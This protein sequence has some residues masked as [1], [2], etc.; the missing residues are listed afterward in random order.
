MRGIR[1]RLMLAF[2]VV[3][4]VTA[5][6]ALVL[7][8]V[9]FERRL[10]G[11][12]PEVR[13]QV[14]RRLSV[15]GG[16]FDGFAELSAVAGVS[17]AAGLLAALLLAR[18]LTAPLRSVTRAARRVADGHLDARA[19]GRTG[20]DELG[21]LV[22]DFNAMAASLQALERERAASS[23][24][25]AHELRTP[26]AALTARLR[27]L[28]D[29]VI[30]YDAAEPRRLLRHT[31]V[32]H[33]LVDDLRTLSL[34]DAGRLR[35]DRHVTDLRATVADAVD[36]HT[37]LA[38]DR[39]VGLTLA[40]V[41]AGAVLVDA[42]VDRLAQVLANLLDNAV[43]HTPAGGT[44][45]VGVHADDTDAVVV[46]DDTGPG[47]AADDREAVFDRF[48]QLDPSRRAH[49][50]GSGLGLAIV[51]ALVGAHG[52][53]VAIGAAPGG[54]ASVEVR[55]PRGGAAPPWGAGQPARR[56]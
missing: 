42:D 52:G 15:A 48:R 35:L 43:R 49:P 24:A 9:Y 1:A 39:R 56:R 6:A 18:W 37:S 10:T 54:G 30:D 55:L 23:A 27:A 50:G 31:A 51:R 8:L 33:R 46:V 5:A 41:P 20:R 53:R 14:D 26:L 40:G 36:A 44:V 19:T 11:L 21:R 47:I 2:G 17:L 25:V 4:V 29:G 13:D 16:D 28:H 32:L 34:A 38:A 45:T 7:A 12:P 3:A 22:T